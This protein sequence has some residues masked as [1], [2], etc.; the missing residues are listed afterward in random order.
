MT[1]S[2]ERILNSAELLFGERGVATT[3]LRAISSAAGVNLAAIHYY[4][5][6]RERLIQAVFTRRLA[7]LN[8]QRLELLDQCEARHRDGQL[9]LKEVIHAFIDP[10]LALRIDGS[11]QMLI[12]RIY[13]EPGHLLSAIVVD[14]ESRIAPRFQV[15]LQRALPEIHAVDLYWGA[16]FTIGMVACAMRGASLLRVISGEAFNPAE[17]EA[18]AKRI[19]AFVCAGLRSFAG[20]MPDLNH[21]VA[22]GVTLTTRPQ[23]AQEDNP[24]DECNQQEPEVYE[25]ASSA[26]LRTVYS[27]EHHHVSSPPAGKC[28]QPENEHAGSHAGTCR[29][30][31][32]APVRGN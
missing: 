24:G 26:R 29:A 25:P 12:S 27:N 7:S 2:K 8:E 31:Q 19:V 16:F 14:Y 20:E 15:A 4:F 1:N 11:C 18:T 9:P 6:S 32:P 23:Q 28:A 5:G 10:L 22:A 30:L 17:T 3:S 13:A 21:P